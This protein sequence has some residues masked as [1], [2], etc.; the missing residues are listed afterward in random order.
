[1]R[2][3]VV[4][5]QWLGVQWSGVEWDGFGKLTAGHSRSFISLCVMANRRKDGCSADYLSAL[6]T[7]LQFTH[8]FNSS[9]H[10]TNFISHLF[11]LQRKKNSMSFESVVCKFSVIVFPVFL[12]TIQLLLEKRD[13]QLNCSVCCSHVWKHSWLMICYVCILIHLIEGMYSI[14]QDKL[15]S[16]LGVW[17]PC[18]K[19][20]SH[21]LM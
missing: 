6:K 15:W 1:M 12:I 9:S 19:L 11:E 10:Q 17:S 5:I 3:D 13:M 8:T 2:S 14:L 7:S 21:N 20:I 18:N 4:N 16:S